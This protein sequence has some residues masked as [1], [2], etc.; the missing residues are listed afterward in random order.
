MILS[1][2]VREISTYVNGT[3]PKKLFLIYAS[4]CFMTF[5]NT[6]SMLW[7]ASPLR[8]LIRSIIKCYSVSIWTEGIIVCG[9]QR[10]SCKVIDFKLEGL[11]RYQWK[12]FF[13]YYYY[14]YYYYRCIFSQAFSSC[15]F[16]WNS[17]DP[18][19]SDFIFTLQCFLY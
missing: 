4:E 16:P 1:I 5:S 11:Y 9:Y 12:N 15:Y 18:H 13:Y 6:Y 2:Y 7:R 14:Y 10:Y 3:L 17:G 19:R 8:V